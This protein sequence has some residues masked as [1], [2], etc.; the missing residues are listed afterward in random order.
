[1]ININCW[2]L[3][4]QIAFGLAPFLIGWVGVSISF[5]IACSN[6]FKV[7]LAALPNSLW[8][9][10]QKALWGASRLKS[11][12]YLVCTICGALLY[13]QYGVRRGLF[14][15]DEM[16]SFPKSLKY[17]MIASVWLTG[18]GF[19]W[20]FISLGLYKLAEG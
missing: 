2:P 18:I 13:P 17:R 4:T 14:E 12:W 20:I 8:V 11:R 16:R 7:M 5:Y 3:S 15:V 19:V 10:Q 6:D 1:M 9:K